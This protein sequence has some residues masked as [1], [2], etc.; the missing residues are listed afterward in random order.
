MICVAKYVSDEIGTHQ[1]LRNL[2]V[3]LHFSYILGTKN[4]GRRFLNYQ[5]N[6]RIYHAYTSK[7]CIN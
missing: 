3:S 6:V 5:I 1:F 2:A 7:V 4:T